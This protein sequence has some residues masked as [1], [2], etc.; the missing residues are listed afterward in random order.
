MSMHKYV[1]FPERN[2]P[3]VPLSESRPIITLPIDALI[4][5]SLEKILSQAT[6]KTVCLE[7]GVISLEKPVVL[8]NLSDVVLQGSTDERNPT[9]IHYSGNG[10]QLR[11]CSN[12]VLAYLSL[13]GPHPYAVEATGIAVSSSPHV[14]VYRCDVRSFARALV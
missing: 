3:H 4:S 11:R 14:F 13:E 12:V 1:P 7:P 10:F 5:P 9:I 2:K 6:G 8:Q